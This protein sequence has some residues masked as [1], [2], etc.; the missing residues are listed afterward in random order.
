[1][2][3]KIDDKYKNIES[4]KIKLIQSYENIEAILKDQ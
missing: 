3:Q 1:L 4:T 2:W